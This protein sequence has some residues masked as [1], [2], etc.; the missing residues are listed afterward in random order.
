[1]SNPFVALL[2]LLP[3]YPLQVGNVAA[4]T[5]GIATLRMPDGKFIRARGAA[6][7]GQS[8]FVRNG[9]IEGE[10]PALTVIEIEI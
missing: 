10:A 2:N 9:V 7:V 3:S 8:V 6:T 4:V 5:D 1:M